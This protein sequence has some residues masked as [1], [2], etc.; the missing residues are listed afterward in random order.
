MNE[1]IKITSHKSEPSLNSPQFTIIIGQAKTK[2]RQVQNNYEILTKLIGS[3]DIV[4]SLD[5][6]L[7]N[8]PYQRRMP[9]IQD[10]LESI[11]ALNLE[12]KLMKVTSPSSQSFLSMLFREKDTEN[13][14]ILAYIPNEIWMNGTFKE[15]L[16]F[17]GARYF[18]TKDNS[19]S[20]AILDDMQK[21]TDDE[22]LD[23]FR[24]IIFNSVYVSSMGICSKYLSLSE[25]EKMMII[26]NNT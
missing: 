24:L 19:N 5:S 10:F 15:I 26:Q 22:K 13:Q 3:S 18:I 23:Y 2:N 25:L 4:I 20:P 9:L 12:Y 16:P 1:K 17:Y 11:R 14:E 7:M 8:L 21:M 6:T